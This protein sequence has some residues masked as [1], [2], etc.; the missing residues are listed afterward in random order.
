MHVFASTRVQMFVYPT[1]SVAMPCLRPRPSRGKQKRAFHVGKMGMDVDA[2]SC[3]E[4]QKCSFRLNEMIVWMRTDRG[5]YAERRTST[6]T[7]TVR[8]RCRLSGPK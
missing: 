6:R 7:W 5:R 8:K 4:K 3:T 2:V 1:A